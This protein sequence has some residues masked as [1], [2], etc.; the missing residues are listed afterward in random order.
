MHAVR[1]RVRAVL[2]NVA[3][4][5]ERELLLSARPFVGLAVGVGRSGE[6]VPLFVAESSWSAVFQAYLCRA[7]DDLAADDY[8]E[9]A[10]ALVAD[11]ALT[12][13][14]E[15]RRVGLGLCPPKKAS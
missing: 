13:W 11:Y 1:L 5:F 4:D 12:G 10:E 8:G 15:I 7:E 6:D 14:R 3:V 9:D 2:N